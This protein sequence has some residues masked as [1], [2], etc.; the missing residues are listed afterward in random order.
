VTAPQFRY[1]ALCTPVAGG[2]CDSHVDCQ[3]PGKRPL[4]TDWSRHWT[5]ERPEGNAGAVCGPDA[6]LLVIDVDTA[7]AAQVY[8]SWGLPTTYTVATGRGG[9]GRHYYYRWP[10]GLERVPNRLDG[11]EIKGPGRQVVAP[12]SLHKS[13]GRYEPMGG[14]IADLPERLVSRLRGAVTQ[15][16][17][18]GTEEASPAA[19][20]R[21]EEVLEYFPDAEEQHDGNWL[22]LCPAH[23]DHDPSMVVK[24]SGNTLLFNCRTGCSAEEILDAVGLPVSALWPGT[25]LAQKTVGR[26]AAPEHPTVLRVSEILCRPPVE[27]WPGLEG[28]LQKGVTSEIVAA[29]G[30]G[31]SL[32]TLQ[33]CVDLARQDI[34]VLYC[35]LE[36]QAGFT[37]RLR[38]Q[39]QERAAP[40]LPG[41]E[42][43]LVAKLE[44]NL[45]FYNL[46]VALSGGNVE[47]S[48]DRLRA[49]A[50]EYGSDI[51]II[52]TLIRAAPGVDEND[53]A[54]MQGV[55]DSA[56]QLRYKPDL[57]VWL[58]RHAGHDQNRGRGASSVYAALDNSVFISP[59]GNHDG[60]DGRPLIVRVRAD[61]VKDGR[62]AHGLT[63]R[64]HELVLGK[65]V[66]G[67]DWTSVVF[68]REHDLD[69]DQSADWTTVLDLIDRYDD[70]AGMTAPQI[71]AAT[72][73]SASKV[74]KVLKEMAEEG[75]VVRS[76]EG[77]GAFVYSR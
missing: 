44:E 69:E 24:A 23:D 71:K 30:A 70:G 55:V 66:D 40:G 54:Q 26:E 64:R 56:D 76:K 17:L 4:A 39:I 32:W 38:A 6:G 28:L 51:V 5:F 25:E 58:I 62:Q 37:G 63:Y 34:K 21:L 33:H 60:K 9:P 13:G 11:V 12:G 3:S 57:S 27:W 43:A 50:E 36:G 61:K 19:Q 42:A 31:K 18:S 29:S 41:I 52:D 15:H 16:S 75:T 35:A 10:A 74:G 73:W 48:V 67:T 2:G 68:R 8:D 1:V 22:A 65:L 53:N 14:Q 77:K 47:S 49:V 59:I 45:L 7:E 20:A 72:Q 46:R